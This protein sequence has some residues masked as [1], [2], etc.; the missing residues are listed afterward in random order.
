V[1]SER[2]R[3]LD[4]LDEAVAFAIKLALELPEADAQSLAESIEALTGVYQAIHKKAEE[5]RK[6]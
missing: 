4:R 2:C 6:P 3:A 5:E 1:T